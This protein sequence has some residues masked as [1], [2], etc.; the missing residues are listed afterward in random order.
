MSYCI[1]LCFVWMLPSR[2]LLFSEENMEESES[3]GKERD[4]EVEGGENCGQDVLYERR[5]NFHK[6]EI[7][8][9]KSL[10]KQ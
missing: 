6:K 2:A 3:V 8:K 4:T 1:C 9:N 5:I 7:K 10:A